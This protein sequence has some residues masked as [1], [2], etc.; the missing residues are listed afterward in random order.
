MRRGHAVAVNGLSRLPDGRLTGTLSPDVLDSLLCSVKG[1]WKCYRKELRKCQ[2]RLS[3][4]SV[5]D[6]RVE[7]RRLRSSLDLLIH[8]LAPAR[9]HKVHRA[10]K[11]HLD[12]FDELR[13]AQ[14]Q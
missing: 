13:D 7:A 1:R 11:R 6:L 2:R 9:L 3:E 12:S 14:V 4:D 8:F 10:L 5:H